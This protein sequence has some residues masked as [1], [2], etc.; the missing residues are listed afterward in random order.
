MK[1]WLARHAQPLVASGICYGATD[2]AADAALTQQAAESLAQALPPDTL[3]R[4]SPLQ[5]C[6]QLAIALQTIR[7]DCLFNSTTCIDT[8]LVEMDFGHFEGQRWAD[9]SK[10]EVDAWTA[11]FGNHRFGGQESANEVLQRVAQALQDCQTQPADH[12]L[13]ITHA[14]VIRAA[15]LLSHGVMQIEAAE[16]WPRAVPGFGEFTQ[17]VFEAGFD[18]IL[19]I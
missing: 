19:H 3:C 17:L 5:R 8:R 13:W 9:I 7:P 15:T 11:N 4:V 14:G 6:Q 18:Q 12:V 1:L 2:V 10:A 16:Q